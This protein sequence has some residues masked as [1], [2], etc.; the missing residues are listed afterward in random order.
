MGFPKQIS[1]ENYRYDLPQDR[2]AEYPVDQRDRSRLLILQNGTPAADVFHNLH[3][4]LP[5]DGMMVFNDTKVIRARLVFH[6]DTGARIEVFCL[7]PVLPTAEIARAFDSKSPVTWKCLIG[8][9][10]KWRNGKL[11]M[12][13]ETPSGHVNFEAE[14]LARADGAF[15]VRF[16][17]DPSGLSF[18]DVLDA[19]GKVPLPPYIERE[20][21]EEDISRY[22]T[23][24]ARADGS[25]AAPTAGLHFT[26][27]VIKS[28][29]DR[30]IGIDH[31]TLHVSAGTFKPVS[32]DDIRDH[33][34]HTEQVII[35]RKLLEALA[36]KQGTVT[37][38]GTTSMRTLESLYWFGNQLERDPE[39]EFSI[40]Q[41]QPYE[42][43]AQVTTSKALENVLHFMDRKGVGEIR[44]ETSLI[45]V[46]SYQFR[47][48]DILVTNFHMPKSTLL[49]LVAAFAGKEWRSAYQYALDNGFRFLSYGDSCLFFRNDQNL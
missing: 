27:E 20:A 48:V 45:I 9:A 13:L 34:M 38:V 12:I 14:Q 17:W 44:G 32:H 2:I 22:Q 10:K 21:E 43:N 24:Y 6:K 15:L 39:A 4:Y 36:V 11:G 31:V 30:N 47:I 33:E 37:A 29:K 46:P 40:T 7:E 26:E 19:A 49:L 42:N 18:A 25:V 8:N 41:W 28:L 23:I 3:K 16:S 5:D 35:S 1:M